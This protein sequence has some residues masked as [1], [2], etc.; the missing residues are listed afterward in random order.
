MKS[1]DWKSMRMGARKRRLW[2]KNLC[3]FVFKT[4][5]SAW[6]VYLSVKT[7]KMPQGIKQNVSANTQSQVFSA[8][9]V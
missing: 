1:W 6:P 4:A 8:L 5:L 2:F 9:G 3:F 7:V